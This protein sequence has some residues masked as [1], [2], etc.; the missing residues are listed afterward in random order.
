SYLG[1]NIKF[2]QITGVSLAFREMEEL[3]A[4]FIVKALKDLGLFEINTILSPENSFR[5]VGIKEEQRLL[6]NHCLKILGETG[7]IEKHGDDWKI[8]SE[9]Q[10]CHPDLA[11]D[12]L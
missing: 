2:A 10:Q 9:P 4:E 8:I 7:I 1:E 12:N 11:V 6:W 3:S 5:Q